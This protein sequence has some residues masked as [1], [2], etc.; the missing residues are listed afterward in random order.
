GGS[1]MI[2]PGT[3]VRVYL[4]CGITDMRKGDLFHKREGE[5]RII[6]RTVIYDWIEQQIPPGLPESE[7]FASR[8]PI[9]APHPNDPIYALLKGTSP[10]CGPTSEAN[11]HD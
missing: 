8:R 2:G 5:W 10:R 4:A 6:A 11:D 3:G 9:G 7:R 1:S